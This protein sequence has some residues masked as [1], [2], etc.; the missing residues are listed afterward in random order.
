DRSMFNLPNKR[1]AE[2]VLHF[3]LTRL[4]PVICKKEFRDC[5]PV[6]DK[7][8][9]QRFRSICYNWI[10]AIAKV[11]YMWQ[12]IDNFCTKHRPEIDV[13]ESIV[14]R[15]VTKHRISAAD[16]SIKVSDL[17][18][19]ECAQEIRRNHIENT[20]QNG[21]LNLVSLL[22]LWNLSMKMFIE[23]YHQGNYG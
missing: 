6:S 8:Q 21:K 4:D 11:R 12:Q 9:E 7:K 18:L 16:I 13:V 3:L 15:A 23:R 19:R 14:D 1:G 2:Y 22:Q 10:S 5:W 17:L 20:Y